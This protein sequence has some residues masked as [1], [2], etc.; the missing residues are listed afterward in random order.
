MIERDPVWQFW[1]ISRVASQARTILVGKYEIDSDFSKMVEADFKLP[2]LEADQL[3]YQ[4]SR[5]LGS[6]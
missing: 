2:M 6:L 4:V 3:C 1:P 5:I